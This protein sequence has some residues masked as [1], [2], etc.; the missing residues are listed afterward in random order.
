MET[1]S[2]D[3]TELQRSVVIV[4]ID[5]NE[6][7]AETMLN[8]HVYH[9][10]CQTVQ[11]LDPVIIIIVERKTR[12]NIQ[13]LQSEASRMSCKL[14]INAEIIEYRY[15]R[16]SLQRRLSSER[17]NFQPSLL[18]SSA[19]PQIINQ[20]INQSINNNQ[21]ETTWRHVSIFVTRYGRDFVAYR[22]C[23]SEKF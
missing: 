21:W 22:I 18:S 8:V 9:R 2:C 6:W 7:Q 3:G 17:S 5:T 20:S 14:C 12:C 16:R 23:I 11:L 10:Q 15:R 13:S 1:E 4:V 19:A